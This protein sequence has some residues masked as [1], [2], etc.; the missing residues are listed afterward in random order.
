LG[1]RP[2]TT[3]FKEQNKVATTKS[4]KP[5]AVEESSLDEDDIWAELVSDNAV[6]PLK[7][8]GIVLPQ[9]TKQQVDAWRVATSAEEGEKALFGD[10]YDA[11]HALFKEQPEYVWENFNVKYLKHMF[12]TAGESD[13]GK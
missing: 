13:L 7:V 8:R 2:V 3:Q 6:P 11:I 9:P 4:T 5:A 10:Q 12:G 1:F